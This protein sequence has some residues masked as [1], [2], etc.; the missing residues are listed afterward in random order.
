[1][2]QAERIVKDLDWSGSTNPIGS[3]GPSGSGQHKR[4]RFPDQEPVG[5]RPER[6]AEMQTSGHKRSAETDAERLEKEVTSAEAD[7][8]RR[9]ALKRKA[10][11]DPNESEVENTVINSLVEL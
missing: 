11:G 8:D 2:R 10:E 9:P 4:V 5:S 3:S 6:D 1:M 7:S